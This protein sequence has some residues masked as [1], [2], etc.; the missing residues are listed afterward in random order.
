[1]VIPNN[2]IKKYS[3][4]VLIEISLE[5]EKDVIATD[6][7]LRIFCSEIYYIDV[8]ETNIIHFNNVASILL[9]EIARRYKKKQKRIKIIENILS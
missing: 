5:L 2:N 7:I 3:F 4:D 8:K 6:S 1:M 9:L